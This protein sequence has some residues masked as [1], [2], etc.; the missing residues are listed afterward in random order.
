[1]SSSFPIQGSSGLDV[2]SIVNS[3]T[4]QKR[5][6]YNARTSAKRYSVET[7]ISGIGILK[8]NLSSFKDTL[9]KTLSKK[10]ILTG[11]T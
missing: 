5:N 11:E 1:M 6:A 8:S 3:L 9:A 10:D 4:Q 2:T 7:S